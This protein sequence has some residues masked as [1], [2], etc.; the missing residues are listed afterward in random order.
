[1]SENPLI[2]RE[3]I[4]RRM[5]DTARAMFET[6]TRDAALVEALPL[7]LMGTE[8]DFGYVYKHGSAYGVSMNCRKAVDALFAL[9]DLKLSD[10]V[11]SKKHTGDVLPKG[12]PI[13]N[14]IPF[15]AEE[16]DLIQVGSRTV[17]IF[18]YSDFS[19]YSA[20]LTWMELPAFGPV[21]LRIQLREDPVRLVRCAGGSG[22]KCD[23][24]DDFSR[25]EWPVTSEIYPSTHCDG[26]SG[27]Y[28]AYKPAEA[29]EKGNANAT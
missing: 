12:S 1:M 14:M 8:L 21:Y 16:S 17:L 4:A 22:W 3:S 20:M 5:R 13:I 26:D 15:C 29:A 18:Q 7:A 28:Y 24:M 10:L 6:Q 27:V 9:R 23:Y 25:S 2:R 11:L 19:Q